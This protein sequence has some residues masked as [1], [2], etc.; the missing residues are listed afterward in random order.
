[1]ANFASVEEAN[2]AYDELNE[3]FAKK[4][5]EYNELNSKYVKVYEKVF[6]ENKGDNTVDE[7][8]EFCEKRFNK[9]DK[10]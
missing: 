10:K 4:E 9:G 1:M 7:F 6:F 8:N 2:K 5:N 3:K